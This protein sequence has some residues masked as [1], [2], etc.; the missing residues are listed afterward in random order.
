LKLLTFR[1]KTL[2]H[3][4]FSQF[5]PLKVNTCL[6]KGE[7]IKT[8]D[9]PDYKLAEKFD[10]LF[11]AY[12]MP[13]FDSKKEKKSATCLTTNIHCKQGLVLLQLIL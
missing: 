3:E 6:L 2:F 7:E 11:P 9:K 13:K 4:A 10:H 12:H 5:V 1:C 8:F